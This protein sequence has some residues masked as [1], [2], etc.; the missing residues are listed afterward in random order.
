MFVPKALLL[1]PIVYCIENNFINVSYL[2]CTYFVHA[3]I[4]SDSQIG[5]ACVFNVCVCV[6]VSGV[7]GIPVFYNWIP[8]H[9][10]IVVLQPM[11]GIM[12]KLLDFRYFHARF[13]TTTYHQAHPIR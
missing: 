1:E 7:P 6:L 11:A 5:E 9:C 4:Y 8:F 10:G 12:F 2:V 13:C 3:S